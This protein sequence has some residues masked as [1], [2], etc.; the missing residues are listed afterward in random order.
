VF[1]TAK[2]VAVVALAVTAL[3][4]FARPALAVVPTNTQLNSYT[5]DIDGDGT[6]IASDDDDKAI[7]KNFCA[8]Y[9]RWDWLE[10]LERGNGGI[11]WPRLDHVWWNSDST[12][13]TE[14]VKY[15]CHAGDGTNNNLT[16]GFGFMFDASNNK[17]RDYIRG[18]MDCD[19]NNSAAQAWSDLLNCTNLHPEGWKT[20]WSHDFTADTDQCVNIDY[21]QATVPVQYEQDANNVCTVAEAAAGGGADPEAMAQM[22]GIM[23]AVGLA[24]VV[25]GQFRYRP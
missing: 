12:G 19:N 24:W 4:L 22:F 18:K 5:I 16:G 25:I 9:M 10:A 2:S 1:S 6:N 15:Q 8:G 11:S 23:L 17:F 7:A 21:V 13:S 3:G 20:Y 14:A